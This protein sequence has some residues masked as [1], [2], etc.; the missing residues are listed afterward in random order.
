MGSVFYIFSV[1]FQIVNDCFYL[2]PLQQPPAPMVEGLGFSQLTK[3]T[4]LI[5]ITTHLVQGLGLQSSKRSMTKCLLCEYLFLVIDGATVALRCFE[6]RLLLFV[7]WQFKP[8][9]FAM[10]MGRF[11]I[12]VLAS[13]FGLTINCNFISIFQ[14]LFSN[15][16]LNSLLLHGSCYWFKE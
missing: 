5:A 9:K 6:F 8:M 4:S 2:P 14:Y 12:I 7:L 3:F 10:N 1:Q 16:D 13:Y 15:K 11:V